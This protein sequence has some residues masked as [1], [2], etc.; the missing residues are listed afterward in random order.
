VS[1]DL[2]RPSPA[3]ERATVLRQRVGDA[4]AA[5]FRLPGVDDPAPASNHL[6]WVCGWAAALGLG[7][8][9]VALRA[10]VGFMM[11]Q[12]SWF[13]PAVVAVGVVGLL[14]TIGAFASVHRNRLPLALL[15]VATGALVLDWFLTG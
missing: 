1:V 8:M 15:G 2:S 3:R 7:G 14:C 6:A 4:V 9:A 5:R 11:V 12:P 10:F 13:G